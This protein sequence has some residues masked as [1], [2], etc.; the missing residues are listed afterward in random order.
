MKLKISKLAL[1]WDELQMLAK[2]DAL[3]I[4]GLVWCDFLFVAGAH[5]EVVE[6]VLVNCQDGCDKFSTDN[7][8]LV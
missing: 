3:D 7:C 5:I 6:D 1:I 2:D 4:G 8:F